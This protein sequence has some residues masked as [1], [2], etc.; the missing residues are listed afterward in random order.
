M[1]R[2]CGDPAPAHGTSAPPRRIAR[3]FLTR[4][5]ARDARKI[6]PQQQNRRAA[7][8]PAPPPVPPALSPRSWLST[9]AA[10]APAR[11]STFP[12]FHL[13]R[14]SSSPVL[15]STLPSG[16]SQPVRQHTP[17]VGSLRPVRHTATHRSPSACA[18][19][20]GALHRECRA[21][22]VAVP[23]T[24]LPICCSPR[25]RGIHHRLSHPPLELRKG[26]AGTCNIVESPGRDP[27]VWDRRPICPVGA[28]RAAHPVTSQSGRFSCSSQPIRN[29]ISSVSM[30]TNCARLQPHRLRPTP[31]FL[32]VS[33]TAKQRGPAGLGPSVDRQ[34]LAG[35]ACWHSALDA[36]R[37]WHPY[38]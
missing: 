10:A 15:R 5:R 16:V 17:G 6:A 24:A 1:K 8:A 9:L 14:P 34:C 38:T 22:R 32:L 7:G 30:P 31:A 37:A 36:N 13:N 21:W 25:P 19:R 18:L 4:S 35:G 11:R 26:N 27:S 20:N 3:A 33:M 2:A 23:P 28:A 12:S 29:T